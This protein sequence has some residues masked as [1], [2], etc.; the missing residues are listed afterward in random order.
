MPQLLLLKPEVLL[1]IHLDHPI[2]LKPTE[3]T[4]ASRK[5]NHN[6]LPNPPM[7]LNS[8]DMA[9]LSNTNKILP[10]LHSNMASPNT[11]NNPSMEPLPQA[12]QLLPQRKDSWVCFKARWEV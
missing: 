9:N 5:V 12:K 1:L 3:T 2:R 6:T 8:Q 7:L 10:I 11:A 4:T